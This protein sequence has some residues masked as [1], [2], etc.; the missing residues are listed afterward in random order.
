MKGKSK[1]SSALG[2]REQRQK[3]PSLVAEGLSAY[4]IA[5]WGLLYMRTVI[6]T[7]EE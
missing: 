7:T 3:Q 6:H 5:V 4:I 1:V 2:G